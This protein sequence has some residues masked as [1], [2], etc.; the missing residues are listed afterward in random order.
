MIIIRVQSVFMS[1]LFVNAIWPQFSMKLKNKRTVEN[2]FSIYCMICDKAG[3][4]FLD[5]NHAQVQDYFDSL[6]DEGLS[7][8]TIL[9]RLSAMRSISDFIISKKT[10][11]GLPEDYHNVFYH[12][13]VDFPDEMI[14]RTDIPS[15]QELNDILLA[16]DGDMLMKLIFSMVIRCGFT[17]SEVCKMKVSQIREDADGRFCVVF[18]E[19]D[20]IRYVKLPEDVVDILM[21][22]KKQLPLSA[23]YMF[24][25]KKNFVLKVRNLETL[26]RKYVRKAGISKDYTIQDIRN[27]ALC[28][29]K[30]FGA[31]DADIADYVGIEERWM[32]RYDKVVDELNLQPVDLVKIRI[33]P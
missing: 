32:Y 20:K 15:M 33:I 26:V 17:A 8:T 27:G 1:D 2:Y 12:I 19:R 11:F 22:Y 28:Y 29:M 4:D 25:N 5:L 23:E 6:R 16:A 18:Q 9:S 30:A 31:K 3:C 21:M 24:Y 14:K 13:R 10:T 7:K